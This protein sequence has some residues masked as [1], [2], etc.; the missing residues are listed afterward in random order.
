MNPSENVISKY[1][2][3]YITSSEKLSAFSE[4]VNEMPALQNGM[5]RKDF[6][7]AQNFE[8][9]KLNSFSSNRSVLENVEVSTSQKAV[10]QINPV[11]ETTTKYIWVDDGAESDHFIASFSGSYP[12]K[13]SDFSAASRHGADFRGNKPVFEYF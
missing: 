12:G 3:R 10:Q 2:T 9:P 5:Y 6:K 13:L 8:I 4:N 11:V 1:R 7:S